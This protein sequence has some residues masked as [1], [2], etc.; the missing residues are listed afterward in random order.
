V[1]EREDPPEPRRDTE[2][3]PSEPRRAS[4]EAPPEPDWAAEIRRLRRARG[5]RLKEVFATFDDDEQEER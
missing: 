3:A 1:S 5:D 4:P 2:R